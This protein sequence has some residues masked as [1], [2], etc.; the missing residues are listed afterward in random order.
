M[1]PPAPV[2]SVTAPLT[3]GARRAQLL[4][5]RQPTSGVRRRH[6][7]GTMRLRGMTFR[8]VGYGLASAIFTASASAQQVAPKPA[9]PLD[10]IPAILDA[11]RSH[12]IVA[13]GDAHGTAQA[14][15]FLKALVRDARF[16][17]TVDDIVV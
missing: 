3:A 10:P 12:E 9:V 14:Q 13:L 8:A 2:D 17:T 11:F 6:A 4:I 15:A 7:R 5:A 16:A 1:S